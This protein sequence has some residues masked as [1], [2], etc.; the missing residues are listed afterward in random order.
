MGVVCGEASEWVGKFLEKIFGL[1]LGW[2]IE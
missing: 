2:G 1:R